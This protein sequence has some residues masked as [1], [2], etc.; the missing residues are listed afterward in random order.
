MRAPSL[1]WR[2]MGATAPCAGEGVGSVHADR[3]RLVRDVEQPAALVDGH[4]VVGEDERDDGHQLHHDVDR[5]AR[6]VLERIT[7]RVAADRSLV[8]LGPL[9]LRDRYAIDQ[10]G[11]AALLDVLLGVVPRTARVRLRDGELHARDERADEKAGD[12]INAEKSADDDRGEDDEHA[13][14]HHLLERGVGRNLD[15]L[16]VVGG[17][18]AR[19]ALEKAGDLGELARDLLDHRHGGGAHGLHRH[20]REPVG[21]HRTHEEHAERDRGEHVH[22]SRPAADARDESAEERER[23]ERRRA[24]REALADGRGG[25]AGRVESVGLVTD[26]GGEL[27][28][29]GHAAGVVADRAVHVDGEAGGEGAEEAERAERNAVHAGEGEGNEGDDCD[30]GD[31]DDRGLVAERE[32]VDDI[33]GGAGLAGLRDLADGGV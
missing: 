10:D 18:M 33:G 8:Q 23:D 1:L 7:N 11:D 24:D 6:G 5:R 16:G 14:R 19:G 27:G 21:E 20:G 17:A 31:G 28:H 4:E 13:G 15:A 25:V 22:A 30:D 32:S 9:A 12:G 29:L 2:A 3:E 26:G